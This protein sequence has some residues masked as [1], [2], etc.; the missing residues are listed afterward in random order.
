MFN[1]TSLFLA[2]IG[3]GEELMIQGG[4]EVQEELCRDEIVCWCHPQ[5]NVSRVPGSPRP[6]IVG[7]YVG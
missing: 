2:G 4:D 1:L 7:K 3:G 6:K 5:K